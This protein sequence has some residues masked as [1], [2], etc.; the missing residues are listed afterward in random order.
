MFRGK[1]ITSS[2]NKVTHPAGIDFFFSL[3]Q[4]VCIFIW[5]FGLFVKD[6]WKRL[7]TPLRW[8]D[9]EGK[10]LLQVHVITVLTAYAPT[11]RVVLNLDWWRGRRKSDSQP[12]AWVI[13]WCSLQGNMQ[14]TI[15][16]C[17]DSLYRLTDNVIVIRGLQYWLLFVKWKFKFTSDRKTVVIKPHSGPSCGTSMH[18]KSNTHTTWGQFYEQ[19]TLKLV[20]YTV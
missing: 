20:C 7:A 12:A 9:V 1:L 3:I 10:H 13:P 2:H 16:H 15:P 14:M 17:T 6:G 19:G 5:H 8:L 11:R 18:W 4:L